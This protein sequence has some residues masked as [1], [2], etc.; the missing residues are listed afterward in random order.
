MTPTTN[1]TTCHYDPQPWHPKSMYCTTSNVET[2]YGKISKHRDVDVKQ[3]YRDDHLNG[4]TSN[5]KAPEIT[6]VDENVD[7]N[8][9]LATSTSYCLGRILD[10]MQGVASSVVYVLYSS[11]MKTSPL[12]SIAPVG[13]RTSHD[14][15]SQICGEPSGS[16]APMNDLSSGTLGFETGTLTSLV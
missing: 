15:K 14:A 6:F 9:V 7:A 1:T 11:S 12:F 16:M 8:A 10:A 4:C 3:C 5:Q 2:M 13:Q